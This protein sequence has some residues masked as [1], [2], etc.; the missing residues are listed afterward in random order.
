[1]RTLMAVVATGLVV[2]VGSTPANAAFFT[3]EASFL[4]AVNPGSYTETFDTPIPGFI[5]PD[6]DGNY[7]GPPTAVFTGPGGAFGYT[8][9][10]PPITLGNENGL[11]QSNAGGFNNSRFL[12]NQVA[13]S[14]LTVTFSA[15][16]VT[17]FGGYF[18]ETLIDTS[19]SNRFTQLSIDGG[20]PITLQPAGSPNGSYF[21]VTS[22]TPITSFTLSGPGG[23]HDFV[24]IDNLTVGVAD[25]AQLNAVP[26]PPTVA[27][28]SPEA[29]PAS[30]VHSS[31]TPT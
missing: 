30:F 29:R 3:T 10:T 12:S 5:G 16:N 25:P 17:A 7:F 13:G 11:F 23:D 4:A 26:L 20:A 31:R 1:M 24:T 19:Y 28:A 8:I 6:Q 2:L 22:A 18:Y 14:N 21:G 27:L 9:S 15:N